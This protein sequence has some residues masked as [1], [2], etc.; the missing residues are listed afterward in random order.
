[1]VLGDEGAQVTASLNQDGPGGRAYAGL[2]Q[3]AGVRVSMHG[4][5]RWMDNVF[6]ERLRRSVTYECVYLHALETGSELRAGL[7]NSIGYYNG[8]RPHSALAGRTPNEAY[9]GTTTEKLAA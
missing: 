2:L 9:A 5:G 1:M 3:A 4:R 6:I 8:R 7:A